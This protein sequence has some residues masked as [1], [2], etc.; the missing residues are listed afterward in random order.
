MTFK[1]YTKR[2]IRFIKI[3]QEHD[4]Q[5]KV[6]S[7]SVLRERIHEDR[8]ITVLP[9]LSEWLSKHK[10]TNL[11]HYHIATLIMHEGREGI[12]VIIN[13]W[14]D[15][16]MLQHYVYFASYDDPTNF[17]LYSGNGII[18]CVWELAVIWFERNA[19]VEH[20]LIKSDHP[21]FTSYLQTHMNIDI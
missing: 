14:L 3:I 10:N 7:I 16:N 4:W 11:A 1:P 9:K 8:I 2:P 19:W 20:V 18:S 17:T 5:I 12:F 21:D 13:W 15:E 6:Y